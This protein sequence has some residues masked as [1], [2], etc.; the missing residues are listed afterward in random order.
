MKEIVI[1]ITP[2]AYSRWKWAAYARWLAA[3]FAVKA[4]YV[5]IDIARVLSDDFSIEVHERRLGRWDE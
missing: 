1:R 5:W 3:A 2:S 4:A